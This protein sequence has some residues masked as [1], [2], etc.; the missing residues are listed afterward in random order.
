MLVEEGGGYY[1]RMKGVGRKDGSWEKGRALIEE[2]R[3]KESSLPV[4]NILKYL[5]LIF[6]LASHSLPFCYPPSLIFT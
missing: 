1:R 3:R 6:T 5:I 2:V 4:Y